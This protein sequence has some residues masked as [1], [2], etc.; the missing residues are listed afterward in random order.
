[1][2]ESAR[3]AEPTVIDLKREARRLALLRATPQ[4]TKPNPPND[5]KAAA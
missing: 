2:S 5:P 1:M 4:P 3:K